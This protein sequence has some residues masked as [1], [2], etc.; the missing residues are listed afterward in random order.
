MEKTDDSRRVR[1]AHEASTAC[2]YQGLGHGQLLHTTHQ[3]FRALRS[4]TQLQEDIK[5]VNEKNPDTSPLAYTQPLQPFLKPSIQP[6]DVKSEYAAE[7]EYNRIV[8][9]GDRAKSTRIWI[10]TKDMRQ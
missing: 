1:E 2:R 8:K 7:N 9:T 5:W 4:D 3:R 6:L 10:P